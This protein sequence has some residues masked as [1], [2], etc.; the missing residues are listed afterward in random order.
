LR[1]CG[2]AFGQDALIRRRSSRAAKI[3]VAAM[4]SRT[5]KITIETEQLLLVRQ[6]RTVVTF[7]PDCQAEVEAMLLG[8]AGELAQLLS[9]LGGA[10]VHI[11][12]PEGSST[13]ICLPS[14]LRHDRPKDVQQVHIPERM[15]PNEGEGK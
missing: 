7:C 11:W 2:A 10:E 12:R 15:L 5:T 4:I 13:H 8:D 3:R 1:T 6:G 9:G 14:L